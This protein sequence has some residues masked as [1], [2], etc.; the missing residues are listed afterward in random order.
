LAEL[1]PDQ[2]VAIT[3]RVPRKLFM[4]V[5]PPPATVTQRTVMQHFGIPPRAYLDLVRDGTI[6]VKRIGHLRAPPTKMSATSALTPLAESNL[7]WGSVTRG[8]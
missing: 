3:L 5:A 1:D 7:P 8:P 2:V 4:M 6:A